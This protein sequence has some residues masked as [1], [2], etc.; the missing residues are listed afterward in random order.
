MANK[1][2]LLVEDDRAIREILELKLN[3]AGFSVKIAE[4]GEQAIEQL[5]TGKFDLI[6]MDLIMPQMNGF[7]L[8]EKLHGLNNQIP[9]IVM[10]NLDQP[11]DI[12]KVKK[13]GAI[14]FLS[15]FETT[16]TGIVDY[17][18]KYFEGQ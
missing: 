17:V 3:N 6:L 1:S 9:K 7:D 5:K 10:S 11:E 18:K 16:I 4:N 13:M 8:L 2:I 14:T 12:E 15:K